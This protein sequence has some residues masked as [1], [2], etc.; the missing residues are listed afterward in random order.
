[1]KTGTP[2]PET[3]PTPH[4]TP[5]VS[6]ARFFAL[7]AMSRSAAAII[8]G[9]ARQSVRQ[10]GVFSLALSGGKT[11]ARLF[12]LLAGIPDF[13]WA[14]THLFW[15]DE[16]LA[17]PDAAESNYRLVREKLLARVDIPPANVHAMVDYLPAG[18]AGGMAGLEDAAARYEAHLR[19]QF[20]TV[21]GQPGESVPCF[22]CIH[23]GMGADGHTASLFPGHPA[24]E[25]GQ[26]L[27]VAVDAPGGIPPLPRLSMTLPLINN[28]RMAVFL[29][30]GADK[31]IALADILDSS[32]P[33]ALP[34]GRV[35]PREE[36]R[37]L[38]TEG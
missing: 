24:L 7:E 1:M 32:S 6:V 35:R 19:Q 20:A 3:Q 37:W 18:A 17:P 15:V 25:E 10:R 23:L 30:A 11:P 13:P 38:V 9:A 21:L 33:S 5:Q 27:I 2:K 8:D 26:R 31:R 29:V 34:A 28:T 12:E 36:L 14:A 4:P 16:R 22:D